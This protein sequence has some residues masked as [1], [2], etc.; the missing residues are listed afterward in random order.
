[1]KLNTLF[2][3]RIYDVYSESVDTTILATTYK[4][5]VNKNPVSFMFTG[6]FVVYMI[7]CFVPT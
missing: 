7:S 2:N 1:M 6:F 3:K 4:L 5:N